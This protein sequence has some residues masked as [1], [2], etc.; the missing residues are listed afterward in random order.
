MFGVVINELLVNL[1]GQDINVF[2]GGNVDDRLQFF[3]RI[4]RAC[5]VARAVHNQHLRAWRHR[6]FEIFRAHFP[7]IALASGHDHGLGAD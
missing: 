2:F 4:N 5:W 3:S 7:G 1:V 6:V